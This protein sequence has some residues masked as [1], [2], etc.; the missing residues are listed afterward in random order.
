[1]ST[2]TALEQ[3][4]H[5]GG[6]T[7]VMPY[8]S[9][10][11]NTTFLVECADGRRYILQRIN[12][13]VFSDPDVLMR[14]IAAVTEHIRRKTA[15]EGRSVA[16]CTLHVI[17]TDSG[18]AYCN[19]REGGS[20][21][22]YD[23][24]D[25]TIAQDHI[26]DR[27]MFEACGE[28]FGRFQ[29]QLADFPADRLVPVIPDFHNT[30]L[31]YASFLRSVERDVAGRAHTVQK[32]IEFVRER[33]EFMQTLE[34]AHATGSLPLRVTHNDTKLNNI[35]FDAVSGQP[36]CVIDLDTVMPG[37]SVNDFGDA[38][39]F[40]AN[41]AAEDERD[42]S[43]VSFDLALYRHYAAGFLRGMGDAATREETELF[44]IGARMM[45]LECGMRFLADYLDG[46]VYFRIH[47]PT[48]NLERARC[49]FALLA[50]ME[51]KADAMR[52]I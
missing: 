51:T 32:E 21:R 3:Y 11:I 14:N 25:G 5:I 47:R 31:R 19:D 41:T 24:V 8:G 45:T 29:R 35:L 34:R 22:M 16:R 48:H 30:P 9:G 4:S 40:G 12:T 26:T 36:V 10:H 23:Y 17:D 7:N 42:L 1:M 18:A 27:S 33:A 37:Y 6:V 52:L 50:D 28:A 15:A 2:E 38:I 43:R 49:Q 44:P 13:A 39:R 20:W 46:D